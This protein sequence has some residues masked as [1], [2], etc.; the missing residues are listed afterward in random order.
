MFTKMC[1]TI[2]Q[3]ITGQRKN[4]DAPKAGI[5]YIFIS[6]TSRRQLLKRIAAPK[7]QFLVKNPINVSGRYRIH[8]EDNHAFLFVGRLSLEKGIA[9]FCKAVHAAHVKGIV[10]GDGDIRT[11]LE[12][13]YPDITFTGWLSKEQILEQFKKARCIVFPSI[14]YETFGLTAYEAEAYGIPVIASDLSAASEDAA[15]VYHSQEELETLIRQAAFQDIE[16]LSV[17]TYENFND[18]GTAAYVDELLKIYNTEL[19]S[20]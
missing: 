9:E 6:E 16:A 1:C 4:S 18:M 15:F 5:G 20:E 17:K 10:V 7:N 2:K 12:A 13:Q 8:A 19:A 3:L 14:W 11:E